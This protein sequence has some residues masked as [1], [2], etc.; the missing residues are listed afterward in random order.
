MALSDA[1]LDQLIDRFSKE[2]ES[3]PGPTKQQVKLPDGSV[4]EGTPDELNLLLLQKLQETPVQTPVEQTGPGQP[5]QAAKPT[6]EF[7]TFQKQFMAEPTDGIRYANLAKY[8]FDPIEAIIQ[9]AQYMQTVAPQFEAIQTQYAVSN[10]KDFESTPDNRKVLEDII[11]ARQW[12]KT[13]QSYTDAHAIAQAEGKFETKT[14]LPNATDQEPPKDA[15]Y[16][17]PAPIGESSSDSASSL[18]S[19]QF[20]KA[21]DMPLDKLRGLVESLAPKA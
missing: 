1:D 5:Q 12:A 17:L 11:T 13:P 6:F 16:G 2:S 7:D 15:F 19:D 9:M 10:L 4:V 3:E 8:G 18:T 14:N 20:T 21:Q